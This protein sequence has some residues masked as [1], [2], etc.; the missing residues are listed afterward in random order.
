[1]TRAS[2]TEALTLLPPRSP[3]WYRSVQ[4]IAG[5]AGYA[6]DPVE[7]RR[8]AELFLASEPDAEDRVVY[9]D[10][11]G[12]LA[13][14]ILQTG[15]HELGVRVLDRSEELAGDALLGYPAIRGFHLIVRASVE[16][17]TDD[18][19][20]RQIELAA[21]ADALYR[22]AGS[23]TTVMVVTRD[24]WGEALARAGAVEEAERIVRAGL[25]EMRGAH[26]IYGR[27]H[28]LV[29]LAT[30][31]ADRGDAAA[32]DEAAA[33]ARELLAVPGLSAG[34]VAMGRHLLARTLLARG[35]LDEALELAT[36]AIDA[37]PQ[38]PT[39]QLAMEA[40]RLYVLTAAGAASRALELA[41]AA[42][43]RME[44][45]G[46]GYAELPLLDA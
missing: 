13:S 43:A 2:C 25:L 3:W 23:A 20:A 33:L 46:G 9:A 26:N 29:T 34:F 41:R 40:T 1:V 14:T 28:A 30:I 15:L 21:R 5:V 37:S 32:L 24:V 39:R 27:T 7:A 44:T 42:L 36:Q 8:C 18:D 35:V 6:N 31:L 10:V 16:R 38:T 45:I 19:L 17:H 22:E 12:S 11:A 4:M